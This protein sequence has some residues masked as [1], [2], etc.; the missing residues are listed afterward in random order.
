M[1]LDPVFLMDHIGQVLMLVIAVSL[2][3]GIIFAGIARLFN[4]GNVVPLAVGLGL[5]QVGEF[6]FVLAG[7][8]VAT[9]SIS[10]DLYSLVLSTAVL[11]MVL[12]PLISGQTAR[13]YAL[14]KRWFRHERLESINVPDEGFRNHV[15]IAGG[16]R[17][18]RQIAGVL[19]RLDL[20]FVLIEL[21]QRRVD[22]ARDSEMPVVYGDASHDIVLEAA[23]ILTARLLLITIPS[24]VVAHATVIH[25]KK[26]AP[27]ITIITR[28]SGM[29]S[30]AIFADQG[31]SEVVLPEFETG[32]EMTRKALL[33]LRIPPTEIQ[34]HTET[35][36]REV[37]AP[38]LGNNKH[39]TTLNQL[40]RAE[41]QFDLQWVRLEPS[42][43]L[44]GTTLGES[45]IR[46][47]TGVSVVGILRDDQLIP[48][49]DVHLSF[50]T[51]DHVA[52]IGTDTARSIFETLT[53]VRPPEPGKADT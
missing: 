38:I 12:T 53:R 5:F 15:V 48:N 33:H 3:K 9:E 43:T 21:D 13:V 24:V 34:Y 39:V 17:V 32:Q 23:D 41:Q 25:A 26:M 51:H 40:R 28:A 27:D 37:F 19:K 42:S 44:V 50:Q 1:R 22:Q 4:Y 11:T 36:R 14:R 7:V 45:Q 2:G 47:K 49:P 29:E 31:V 30:I 35:L 8:G 6:S 18:G 20:P 10:H 52:I 46:S 16:G